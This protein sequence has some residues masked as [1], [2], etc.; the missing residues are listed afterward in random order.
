MLLPLL[1]GLRADASPPAG[2]RAFQR[3]FVNVQD[4]MLPT[5]NLGRSVCKSSFSRMK[6]AL[7]HAAA[8]LEPLLHLVRL[9]S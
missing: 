8:A 5:N 4:P 3:K 6:R 9:N 1:E 7:A 2:P